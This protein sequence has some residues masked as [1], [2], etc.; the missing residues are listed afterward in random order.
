M[1]AAKHGHVARMDK[2][3]WIS[4]RIEPELQAAIAAVPASVN[5]AACDGCRVQPGDSGRKI[6]TEDT[7]SLAAWRE[8][9]RLNGL[10]G[11]NMFRVGQCLKVPARSAGAAKPACQNYVVKPIQRRLG[12]RSRWP[13]ITR[14]NGITREKP[15][16]AGPCL[17]L[18]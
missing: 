16:R 18:S 17:K 2:S 7:S 4:I 13:E 1:I 8:L 12:D 11:H 5:N 9:G 3:I 6:L 14:L 10:D 15:H